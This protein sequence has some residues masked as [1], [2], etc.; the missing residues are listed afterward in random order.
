MWTL[1]EDFVGI[2][3]GTML[4]NQSTRFENTGKIKKKATHFRVHVGN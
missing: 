2:L 1:I 3:A 4:K